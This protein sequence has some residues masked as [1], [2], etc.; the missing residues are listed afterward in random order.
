MT[1]LGGPV[2]VRRLSLTLSG[3][4]SGSKIRPPRP[5]P[6][7]LSSRRI[8]SPA[9][10]PCPC[11]SPHRRAPAARLLP[12]LLH[13]DLPQL[14]PAD[15]RGGHPAHRQQQQL[16]QHSPAVAPLGPQP[17]GRAGH[18]SGVWVAAAGGAAAHQPPLAARGRAHGGWVLWALWVGEGWNERRVLWVLWVGEGWI[19]WLG[20]CRLC[21]CGVEVNV[22][23]SMRQV[24][25]S[26]LK[27]TRLL[28][29][30]LRCC[31]LACP[32]LLRCCPAT[33][34]CHPHR[35]GP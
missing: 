21:A 5:H 12:R 15:G 22:L 16:L 3:A 25:L 32:S 4:V 6:F 18:L 33:P 9:P 35:R 10:P 19:E 11:P 26:T 8:S 34:N 24:R 13:A 1:M 27:C 20:A 31:A 2:A 28:S 7:F 29:S 17:P 14:L 23:Y 30:V